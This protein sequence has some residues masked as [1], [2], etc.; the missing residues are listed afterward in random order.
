MMPNKSLF[1]PRQI[2]RAHLGMLFWALLV[3][4]SFPVVGLMSEGL[5]PLLLTSIR[6]AIA[7]LA[8]GPLVWRQR[9]GWP[10]LPG[11]VLYVFMGICLSVFFGVMFWVAHRVTA[12]S[13]ATLYVCVPLMA[14]GLGRGLGVESRAGQ[15]LG[16]LMLGALGALGLVWAEA[17]G[18]F[19]EL[20]FGLGELAY[21]GGCLASAL[22]P[23]L[24]KWGLHKG[25]LSKQASTRTFWSLLSGSFLIGFFGLV[26][27]APLALTTM[28]LSDIFLLL[29]LGV[30]SSG[31]TFWLQHG[32][33]AVLTPGAVMAYS[34][35]VPFVSMLLLFFAQP[36]LMTWYWLPG[37]VL[38]VAAITLLL[39]Q[40]VVADS[41][42]GVPQ[43]K[44][45]SN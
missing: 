28:T 33:T 23:V 34:Y 36:E 24:S 25:W 26:W 27:E 29:Y 13:M 37:N 11:V 6:F 2:K 40:P 10:S 35:L 3:G 44:C 1:L 43:W 5:P 21:F 17:G 41:D 32:A 19:A 14:Y 9:E 22:Y 4:L 38:V 30:F 31:M 15:L 16:I 8:I 39:R 7:I 45:S 12:L 18:E 42:L 20:Q